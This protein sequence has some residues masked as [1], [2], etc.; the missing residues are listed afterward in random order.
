MCKSG[1]LQ[2]NHVLIMG[3]T[4]IL[5]FTALT[6]SGRI[7][8]QES[9]IESR[10]LAEQQLDERG[11]VIIRFIKPAEKGLEYYT[12]FLSIDNVKG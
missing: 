5:I 12:S 4:L 1:R 8:A 7:T 3:G 6:Y 11:E 9:L 2:Y 10:K